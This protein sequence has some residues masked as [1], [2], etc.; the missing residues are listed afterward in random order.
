MNKAKTRQF[1]FLQLRPSFL[2]LAMLLIFGVGIDAATAGQQIYVAQTA[3]GSG[4][5]A[6]ASDCKSIASIN[7]TWTGAAGDTVHL[8]GTFTTEL[9]VGGG[10][11]AGNP[12]TILFEPNAKFSAPYWPTAWWG[13]GAITVGTSG[14]GTPYVTIDGG[15]NGVIEATDNGTSLTYQ[16]NAIG[17]SAASCKN[18]TIQNLTIRNMYVRTGSTEKNGNGVA[19]QSRCIAG[20]VTDLTVSNCIITEANI[21]IDSDYGDSCSNYTFIANTITRVNWG[22]RCGDRNSSSHM[23][24]LVVAKNVFNTF[25]NWNETATDLFHHNGFYAWAESGGHLSG[26]RVYGN[27]IGPN[28]G[29]QYCTSGVFFSGRISDILVYNN[30]FKENANDAPANGLI[31]GGFG[32]GYGGMQIYNN[33]FIGHG[34]GQAINIGAGNGLYTVKNN[35]ASGVVTFISDGYNAS[36]TLVCDYNLGYNLNLSQAFSVSATDTSSFN[37]FAQWRN[38]G[39]DLH[40]L[41]ANPNL[42]PNYIPQAGSP[43]IGAG[44]N[45][46]GIFITDFAGN[47]RPASGNWD[48]GA[49]EVVK[50]ASN[51][52]PPPLFL[53]VQT[54]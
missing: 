9:T 27:L 21:G 17:I 31:T 43:A 47:L 24:N 54:Q 20:N 4:S 37:T 6:D 13:G 45:L 41:N 12:V 33:T 18:L 28:F 50:G 35:L 39:F 1:I 15:S 40:G 34:V 19:I 2:P 25:T 11:A 7:T 23:T 49:Y 53:R 44:T 10:G 42:D 52:P 30:V 5:G 16:T 46:S 22:G 8:V 29:N 14:W 36:S 48:I 26:V 38:F 32:N 51:L 3:T